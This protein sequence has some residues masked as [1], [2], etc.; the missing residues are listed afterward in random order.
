[1]PVDLSRL[2]L[3]GQEVELFR[4]L[5]SKAFL[6]R[7]GISNEV[8][9]FIY[10]YPPD[11]ARQVAEM[12][13]RI[14]DKLRTEAGVRVLEINL[15][16]IALDILADMGALDD[17]EDV[18]PTLTKG[19]FREALQGVL[20]P[21]NDLLPMI[22]ARIKANPDAQI[23]FLTGIGEVYPYIRSHNVLTALHNV[24]RDVPLL[25]WFPGTYQESATRGSSLVLFGL[26]GDEKY[27]RARDIR[28]WEVNP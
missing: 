7:R 28:F 26:G 24:V 15:Y 16:D 5:K 27:Y 21:V 19:D 17:L 14:Q 13:R 18:E 25:A 11:Q 3:P 10:P 23:L 8:P 12:C 4:I 9:I 2:P 22:R 20:D 6:E 1:M